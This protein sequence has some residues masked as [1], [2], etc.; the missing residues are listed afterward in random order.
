[1]ACDQDPV[2]YKP[3]SKVDLGPGQSTSFPTWAAWGWTSVYLC[4]LSDKNGNRISLQAGAAA[5]TWVDL[6]P[7]GS[8]ETGGSWA[9]FP[10]QIGNSS[11][12]E[13][14]RVWVW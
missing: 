13:S 11:E 12:T 10:V 5:P 8:R 3:G 1:M 9:G 14:V 6:E 4:N 2:G 7:S